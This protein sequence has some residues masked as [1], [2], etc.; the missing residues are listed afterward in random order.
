MEETPG[1]VGST[2]TGSPHGGPSLPSGKL[3]LRAANDQSSACR[4][5]GKQADTCRY[6]HVPIK[7]K[8][9]GL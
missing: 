1:V 5:Q 9:G 4:L 3:L 6:V 7:Q 2:E 8:G